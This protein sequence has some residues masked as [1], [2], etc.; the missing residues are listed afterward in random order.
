MKWLFIIWLNIV[1]GLIIIQRLKP[2]QVPVYVDAPRIVETVKEV[3]MKLKRLSIRQL[4]TEE[5]RA[6]GGEDN[7]V[8]YEVR[9][10]ILNVVR[11]DDGILI[12]VGE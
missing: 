9:G 5:I 10:K 3:P 7:L 2:V 8:A 1:F 11:A 6:R 4:S 12:V